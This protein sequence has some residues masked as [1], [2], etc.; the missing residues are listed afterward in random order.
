MRSLATNPTGI[1]VG[2]IRNFTERYPH[3]MLRV[4]LQVHLYRYLGRALSA[5]LRPA[6]SAASTAR[7]GS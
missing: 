5:S 4:I 2:T 1:V 3:G 7:T 6:A